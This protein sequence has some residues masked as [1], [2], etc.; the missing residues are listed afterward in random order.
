MFPYMFGYRALLQ[1]STSDKS[2]VCGNLRVVVISNTDCC[3]YTMTN[4]LFCYTMSCL[5]CILSA[6]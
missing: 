6:K 2:L 3:P 5:M 1:D 4:Y